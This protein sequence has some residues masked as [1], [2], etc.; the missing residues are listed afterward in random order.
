MVTTYG[1]NKLNRLI[2]ETVSES[3]GTSVASYSYTLDNAGVVAQ[4]IVTIADFHGNGDG[5]YNGGGPRINGL[6]LGQMQMVAT[7]EKR[8]RIGNRARSLQP[9]SVV[10]GSPSG[11]TI[12]ECLCVVGISSWNAFVR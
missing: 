2:G 6:K 10:L 12:R 4:R 1:Y 11:S 9:Y 3:S 8:E 5:R 7:A